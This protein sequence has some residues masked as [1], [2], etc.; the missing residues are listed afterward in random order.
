M[1]TMRFESSIVES[2]P[3]SSMFNRVKI[4]VAYE[5]LNRN[6]SFISRETFEKA[7][8]TAKFCP[9][10]GEWSDKDQDFKGHGGK[11]VIEDGEVSFIDTTRPFG[12][13]SNEDPT[14]ELVTDTAGNKKEYFTVYGYLWVGRYPEL[15]SIVEQR[16]KNQSMEVLINDGEFQKI[17]GK[18]VYVIKDMTFSGF[19][20][21]GNSVEPCFE[22]ST[23]STYSTYKNDF[24]IML[25]ELKYTLQREMA[26]QSKIKNN[27]QGGHEMAKKKIF[28]QETVETKEEMKKK[29]LEEGK[30]KEKQD[31]KAET[32]EEPK[33]E[34]MAAQEPETEPDGD[35]K[36]KDTDNDGDGK[37][38]LLEKEFNELKEKYSLLESEVKELR[39]FKLEKLK[40]EKEAQINKVFSSVSD[41]LTESDL[42]PFKEK[43][44][45]MEIDDLKKELYALIGQKA[46]EAKKKEKKPS[47]IKMSIQEDTPTDD[48]TIQQSYDAIIKKY[49]RK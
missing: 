37:Y 42:A 14:W 8:E 26:L 17:N 32:K 47:T 12:C 9:I 22:N 43:A 34:E 3:V 31:A 11:V 38:E 24:N 23:I 6:N 46:F 44:F 41:E 39:Q 27:V 45:E 28:Q 10:V 16:F 13:I 1:K 49:V 21:L 29:E 18:D 15:K 40:A 30:E 4:H 5:G 2:K 19:C 36:G 33:Q 35:E 20:I 48:V 25:A 7:A